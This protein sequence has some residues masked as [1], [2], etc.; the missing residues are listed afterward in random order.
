MPRA[1]I[2]L[3]QIVKLPA[4][5][6]HIEIATQ[7]TREKIMTAFVRDLLRAAPGA[8]KLLL[9][10]LLFVVRWRTST[11]VQIF[12]GF[13]NVLRRSGRDLNYVLHWVLFVFTRATCSPRVFVQ[14]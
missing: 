3:S 14:Q 1:R 4:T 11:I 2:W 10:L 8:R 5:L 13:G 7:P 9:H 6:G 12:F